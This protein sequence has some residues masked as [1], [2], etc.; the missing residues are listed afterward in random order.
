[1]PALLLLLPTAAAPAPR[2]AVVDCPPA[3]EWL[4]AVGVES[5]ALSQDQLG[6]PAATDDIQVLVLPM[7]R[8][9]TDETLRQVTA[10]TAR[11]GKVIAVYWGTLARQEWQAQYPLYNAAAY[12]GFRVTG[13]S[14]EG[15]V[16]VKVEPPTP[17][18]SIGDLRLDRVMLVRVVP[19][20][21]TQVLARLAPASGAGSGPVLAL[22]SG[23]IFYVSANLFHT[24]TA[25]AGVRRLFFWV[26]D[27]A[28]PGLTVTQARERAGSAMA[29]VIRARERLGAASAANAEAVRRLLDEAGQAADRAKALASGEQFAESAA[30]ADQSRELTERALK[31]L[32]K[33]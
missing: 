7:D 24:G 8:V 21:S 28:V 26:L 31:L 9:R 10:F 5:R 6:T 25:V 22:R 15:P 13:W 18:G 29:A 20:P 17:P 19:D 11:G 30:A 12:L 33:P 2:V 32:E 14:C 4:Q 1:M 3:S 23:N 16:I 27:Q